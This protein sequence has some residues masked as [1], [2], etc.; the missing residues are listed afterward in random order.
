MIG[1]AQKSSEG[2]GNW[3]NGVVLRKLYDRRASEG[4]I[5][6]EVVG[7]TWRRCGK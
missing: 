5:V 7:R 1:R 3:G 6:V 4:L 2:D